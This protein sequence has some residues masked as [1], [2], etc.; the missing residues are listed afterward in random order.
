MLQ[1]LERE[2]EIQ[3]EDVAELIQGDDEPH[4]TMSDEVIVAACSSQQAADNDNDQIAEE[5][6]KGP[7]R[8]EATIMFQEITLYLEQ[9]EDTPLLSFP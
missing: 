1:Y 7:N 5:P 8:T 3:I 2:S 9:Q 4:L 6:T